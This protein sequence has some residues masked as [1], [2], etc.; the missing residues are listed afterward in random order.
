MTERLEPCRRIVL[1]Q[2]PRKTGVFIVFRR[3][4]WE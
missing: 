1:Q 2:L 4:A 3:T